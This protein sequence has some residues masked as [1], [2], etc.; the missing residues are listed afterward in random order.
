M[1]TIIDKYKEKLV[2]LLDAFDKFCTE[3][4]LNYYASGGTAIG[5]VRHKGF[6]PWDDDIDVVMPRAD[7]NRMIE[8]RNTLD[9]DKYF[10]KT[11]GDEDYLYA[12]GKF[13]DAQTTLVEY[14][15][16]PGCIIGVNIDVFP[17]DEVLDDKETLCIKR[18]KF[19]SLHERFLITYQ[20]LSMRNLLSYI[21]HGEIKKAF[22]SLYYGMLATESIK[23]QTREL[24]VEFEK[25]WQLDKGF[26]LYNHSA[27]YP[28]EKELL[29]KYWFD[30]FI[31]MPFENTKIRMM[32]GY[33][34]YLS[35]L[36]GD[37]MTPPPLDKQ[38]LQHSHYYLNLKERLSKNEI[39]IRLT[40][41]EHFVF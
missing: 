35:Q 17:I 23:I 26:F 9:P 20:K 41:D 10:I 19:H 5:V 40:N 22:E 1:D 2:V 24:F 4:N 27:F 29:S 16:Y 21:R 15:I 36:F 30:D 7:Y 28:L 18:K 33:D 32:K 38:V 34:Q 8:L 37:Y 13:C 6:I 25:E 39:E 11:L 31:Y 3:N 12:Y 14:K